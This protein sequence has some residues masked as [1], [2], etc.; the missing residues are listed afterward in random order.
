MA[1]KPA[2]YAWMPRRPRKFCSLARFETGQPMKR[3]WRCGLQ[4]SYPLLTDRHDVRM[5][6]FNGESVYAHYIAE[7]E[8]AVGCFR[9]FHYIRACIIT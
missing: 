5:Y 2:R 3:R 6:M 8:L 1:R 9:S 7:T 4:A